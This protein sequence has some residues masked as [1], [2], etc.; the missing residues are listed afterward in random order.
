ME[1]QVG[2]LLRER[3][4][5]EVFVTDEPCPPDL[6]EVGVEACRGP[7]HIEGR[8]TSTG[9]GVLVEGR[10]TVPVTL[11]CSR[12]LS[13]YP[14]EVEAHFQ[15]EVRPPDAPPPPGRGRGRGARRGGG[16]RR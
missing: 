15:G 5:A 10:I 2:R 13:P 9:D 6:T 4:R 11:L 1:L 3:G 16:G 7:V 8:A 12:C 14:A